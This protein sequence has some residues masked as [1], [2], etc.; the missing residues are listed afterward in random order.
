MDTA[1]REYQQEIEIITCSVIVF[2]RKLNC[3]KDCHSVSSVHDNDKMINDIVVLNMSW[4]IKKHTVVWRNYQRN[5]IYIRCCNVS[6]GH[7]LILLA[8]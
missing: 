2:D 7:V 6:S 1:M 5:L 8:I 4:K 3:W